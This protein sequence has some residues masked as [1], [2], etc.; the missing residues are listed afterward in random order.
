[1]SELLEWAER[2]E[3]A[4]ARKDFKRAAMAWAMVTALDPASADAKHNL[5]NALAPLGRHFEAAYCF[6]DAL[7]IEPERAD[8]RI[9]L[10]S[11]LLDLGQTADANAILKEAMEIDPS[12]ALAAWNRSLA[13][14]RLG[15]WQEGF[16]L[17]E[18]RL[19]CPGAMPPPV[20]APLW[21]GKHFDGTL[22]VWA[23]QGMGDAIHFARYLKQIPKRVKETILLVHP[24][25]V[26]LFAFSFPMIKVLPLHETVK[27]DRQIA[28]LSLAHLFGFSGP[29]PPYLEADPDHI[30]AW[31][32]ELSG[33]EL[34]VGIAWRGNPNHPADERRSCGLDTL[35]P[36]LAIQDVRFISLQVD[37]TGEEPPPPIENVTHRLTDFAQTAAVISHLD[38]VI[39]PDTALAH[40]A[41]AMNMPCWTA[42][43]FGG[44][45]RWGDAGETTPW[46]PKMRLFR[47]ERSQDWT[48]PMANLSLALWALRALR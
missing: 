4:S 47:Q 23:E 18:N 19:L 1:M 42:L 43:R 36:V 3:T 25:L 22:A 9:S 34:K 29:V 48:A 21:D 15:Q 41:G 45:W 27:A 8:T 20:E 31:R 44:D 30:E 13:L 35:T 24:D 37:A 12:S 5:G 28:L 14:L 38:L 32:A 16:R 46:Y 11:V 33:S 7:E 40:L 26:S 17:F 10:G 2:A 6:L 39:A